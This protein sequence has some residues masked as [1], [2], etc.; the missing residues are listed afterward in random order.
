MNDALLMGMLHRLADGHGQFQPLTRRQPVVVTEGGD[1]DAADQLHHE[2]GTARIGGPGIQHMG[3]MRV[4]HE[5]QRLPFGLEAGHHLL[6]IHAWLEHLERHLTADALLLLRH[7]DDAEAALANLLQQLVRA[8]HRAGA[9]AGSRAGRRRRGQ[10]FTHGQ[11]RDG[12]FLQEAAG[13]QVRIH[14]FFHTRLQGVVGATGAS[15][16]GGALVLRRD[17][18]GRTEDGIQAGLVGSHALTPSLLPE[19]RFQVLTQVRMFSQ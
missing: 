18:D 5:R 4:V 11:Q 2:I 12:E 17:L 15:Q 1:G 10:K 16:V 7:E 13:P 3:D 8:D 9:F 6:A 19:E 14:K